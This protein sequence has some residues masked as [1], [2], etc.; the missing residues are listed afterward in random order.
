MGL[1]SF[2][3]NSDGTIERG[4]RIEPVLW[5][6]L[7]VGSHRK[8]LLAAYRAQ[9]KCFKL[10]KTERDIDYK[11]YVERLQ[12]DHY[13]KEFKKSELGRR[14]FTLFILTGVALCLGSLLFICGI[15]MDFYDEGLVIGH[16]GITLLILAGFGI[17]RIISLVK[18]TKELNNV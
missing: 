15:V 10:A 5:N 9:R 1:D 8:S 12:P 3:I 14:L 18:K 4:E 13:P 2:T 17:W 16:I 11:E 6:I 7:E